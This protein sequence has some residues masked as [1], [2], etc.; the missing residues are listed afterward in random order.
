MAY[1]SPEDAASDVAAARRK[2]ELVAGLD[3]FFPEWREAAVVERTL[4]NARVN[5]AR[6]TPDQ[7]GANAM[8]LR[9]A[10]A[11]NLYY[12]NDARDLPY[13]LTLTCLAASMEVADTIAK[14]HA[15]ESSTAAR[16]PVAV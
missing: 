12:A 14:E 1:L 3:R 10:S 15:P 16:S 13:M 9:A 7:Y 11:S 5:S 6:R 4:P 2:E 8:P